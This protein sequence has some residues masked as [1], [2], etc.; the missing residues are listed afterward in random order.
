LKIIALGTGTSQGIPIIGCK[1]KVCTS[2][3]TADH[4]LRSSIF[5]ESEQT[6][7]LI[8]IGPDFRS[9]FLT[10]QIE[11]VDAVL[12]THEH[13][14]HIIGLDDIRAINFTQMKSIPIYAAERVCKELTDRFEYVFRANPHPSAPQVKLHQIDSKPFII[15]DLNITP[16]NIQHGKL[17]IFGY[18]INNMAYITDASEIPEEEIEKLQGL[19]LLIIN[20]LRKEK[21]YSHFNLEE[22]L[23]AI[24]RLKPK[25]TY[26]THVSHLMGLNAEWEA[27]LPDKVSS[28]KDRMIIRLDN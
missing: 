7:L 15:N 22:A 11:S 8:D 12:I 17:P 13:N 4:R 3:D 27:T 19:D 9:Q 10:N 21:H 1:C 26:I 23:S 25:K 16:I 28:L 14:D 24:E 20:A 6:K 5:I 2:N 18:R